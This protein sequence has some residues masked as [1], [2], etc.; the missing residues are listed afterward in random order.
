MLYD[1]LK[2][3]ILKLRNKQPLLLVKLIRNPKVIDQ[4]L[5]KDLKLASKIKIL[6]ETIKTKLRFVMDS[7]LRT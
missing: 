4:E 7:F 6:E 5:Y 2:L 1:L 3:N